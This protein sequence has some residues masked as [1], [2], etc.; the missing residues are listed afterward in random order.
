MK[1]II[2]SILVAV[3]LV[4]SLA[5]CGY[6]FMKDDMTKYADFNKTEFENFIKNILIENGEFEADPATREEKVLQTIYQSIAESVTSDKSTESLKTGVPGGRDVVYYAYYATAV[7]D[8]VTAYF[9]TDKLKTTSPTKLQ[10]RDGADFGEDAISEKVAEI[11]ASYDFADFVYSSRTYGK[12]VEGDVAYVTFAKTPAGEGAKVQTY[13]NYKV[14]IAAAPAEGATA[15]TLESYLCGQEIGS[16]KNIAKFEEKDADGNLVATYS[17]IK[18]NWVSSRETVG[19]VEEG[20]K[21]YIS[22][23]KKVGDAKAESKSDV[24]YIV[25]APVAEGET[26]T[27]LE[28]YLA[29]KELLKTLDKLTLT[30]GEDTVVYSNII[31]NWRMGDAES[32]GTFTN[33]TYGE[34]YDEYKIKDTTGTERDLKDVELTYHVYPVYYYAVPEYSSYVLI[35]KMLGKN[36]KEDS[37]LELIFAKELMELDDEATEEDRNEIKKPGKEYKTKEEK[38]RTIAAVVSSIVSYYTTITKAE[39]GLENAEE[40][41]EKAQNAYD[42]ALAAYEAEANAE[43]PDEAKLAELKAALDTADEKLNGKP[44][45]P[46]DKR[47]DAKYGKE[48]AQ[49]AYDDIVEKKDTDIKALL[50]ITVEGGETLDAVI[51]KNQKILTYEYLQILYNEELKTKLAKELYYFINETS[52]LRDGKL[53]EDAVETAYTQIYETYENEFYTGEYDTTNHISNY[54]KYGTFSAYLIKSVSDDI[55]TVT[56]VKEA[57]AAIKEKAR[58]SIT[59]IVNMFLVAANYDQTLTKK[60][61]NA[62]IDE[63]EEYYASY[64]G[65]GAVDVEK[66]VGKINVSAAA[67][68]DKLMDWFL[69][70]EEDKAEA[71]ESGYVKVTYKYKNELIGYEFGDPAS[72]AK[73]ED[74][75]KAE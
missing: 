16:S 32:I 47:N 66:M 48:K 63:L 60:E 9:F 43:T 24:M 5:S 54:T 58:E 59:P 27:T 4:L 6:S 39:E 73:D 75:E 68:F 21:V 34:D 15:A 3:M 37:I 30:E 11:F 29:G 67:Q 62:F 61:Y 20:D 26:A 10:L 19:T 8:D 41:L 28:S 14:N 52:T 12:T 35:D 44:D 46:D 72:E 71:D 31:I 25:G 45:T 23:T 7:F 49:K 70:F 64:L 33:V 40:A 65:T 18:I 57:K 38:A 17:S 50:A 56:T 51:Y 42:E 1:R 74:A 55:K 69:E 2:C 53:P 36:L 22:Y 13:T